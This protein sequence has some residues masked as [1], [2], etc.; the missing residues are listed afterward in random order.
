MLYKLLIYLIIIQYEISH[1]L[2]NYFQCKT[3]HILENYLKS[4]SRSMAV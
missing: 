4:L 1:I 3:T 2:E